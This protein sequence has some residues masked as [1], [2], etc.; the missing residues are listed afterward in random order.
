MKLQPIKKSD[1]PS[2]RTRGS[3]YA[4]ILE[5]FVSSNN[6][7]ARVKEVEQNVNSAATQFRRYAKRDKLPVKIRV[8]G[9]DIY[10]VRE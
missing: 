8:S 10:L 6:E 3:K 7:A 1:L 5:T 4:E 9:K 2:R